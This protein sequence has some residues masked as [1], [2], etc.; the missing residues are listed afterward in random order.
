ME[1]NYDPEEMKERYDLA[2]ERVM[3]IPDEHILEEKFQQ[4]FKKM[5]AFL[6]LMD[7]T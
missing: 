4:Y 2:M 3:E 1:L 5:A 7:E 6:C